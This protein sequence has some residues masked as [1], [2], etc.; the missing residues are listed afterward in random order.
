MGFSI[1][2]E[3]GGDGG[4]GWPRL[5]GRRRSGE[6]HLPSKEGESGP[7]PR[8]FDETSEEKRR[9][10]KR[11]TRGYG[12]VKEERGDIGQLRVRARSEWKEGKT[13]NHHHP[14]KGSV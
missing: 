13:R 11:D 9:G 2:G 12:K 3:N 8:R 10:E 6:L 7:H 14:E 1:D 5:E 4:A